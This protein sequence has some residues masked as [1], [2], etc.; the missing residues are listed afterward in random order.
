MATH[1][2]GITWQMLEVVLSFLKAPL[3]VP[4]VTDRGVYPECMHRIK[5]K[6]IFTLMCTQVINYRNFVLCLIGRPCVICITF[7]DMS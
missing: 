2:Q 4:C 3:L 1:I 7:T 5:S 6:C